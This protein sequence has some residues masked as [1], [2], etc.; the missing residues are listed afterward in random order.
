MNAFTEMFNALFKA[1]QKSFEIQ[2]SS[3]KA[4][5]PFQTKLRPA[6]LQS[7]LRGRLAGNQIESGR[8]VGHARQ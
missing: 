4:F 5:R 7:N 8:L 6:P 1:C 3:D 2:V